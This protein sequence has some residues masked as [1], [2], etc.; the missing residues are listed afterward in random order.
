[1][2]TLTELAQ[3]HAARAFKE[4]DAFDANAVERILELLFL[5]RGFADE[6]EVTEASDKVGI[7]HH[8][9][10][11]G[12]LA[13]LDVA[14]SKLKRAEATPAE[15]EFRDMVKDF[16]ALLK[17]LARQA[18]INETGKL[19]ETQSFLID[20]VPFLPEVGG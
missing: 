18:G 2:S 14:R 3:S 20:K 15:A 13:A 6:S 4:L 8:L 5:E 7:V 9:A 11:R 16:E 10:Y 12:V 1:M 17:R 19:P